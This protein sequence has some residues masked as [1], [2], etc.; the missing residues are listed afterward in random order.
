M[1][2]MR[3]IVAGAMMTGLAACGYKA[4]LTRLDPA[5]PALT[6]TERKAARADERQRVEAGLAVPANARPAR[7]DDQEDRMGRRGDDPFSMPPAGTRGGGD[8]AFP[9]DPAPKDT[10]TPEQT[11]PQR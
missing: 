7:V 4:P 6:K 10:R 2:L 1:G 5:D 9:G 3:A 11:A 8:P